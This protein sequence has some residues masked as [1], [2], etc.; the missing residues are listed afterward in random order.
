MQGPSRGTASRC[1]CSYLPR[2]RTTFSP[3]HFSTDTNQT[4]GTLYMLPI[5]SGSRRLSHYPQHKYHGLT[6][7]PYL[8]NVSDTLDHY[9][10]ADLSSSST[11][12]PHKEECVKRCNVNEDD[13]QPISIEL[14]KCSYTLDTESGVLYNIHN[15]QVAP[16]MVNVSDIWF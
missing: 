9:Y 5:S 1:Q 7:S 2:P 13:R 11:K 8:Y 4:V 15:R 10:S 14:G 6:L 12:T 16:T 3:L